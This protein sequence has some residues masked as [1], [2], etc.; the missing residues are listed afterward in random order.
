M[1][2]AD[3]LRDPGNG[4]LSHTRLWANVAYAAGTAAFVWQSCHGG[5]AADIWLIYLGVV[6]ASATAS[7]WL[8]LRFSKDA[9][10][11]AGATRGRDA[12]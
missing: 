2:L 8:S 7:K 6:G 5:V 10:R 12:A 1:N 3:L 9:G 4:R 11:D